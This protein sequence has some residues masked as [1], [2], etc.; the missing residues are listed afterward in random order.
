VEE[1][2]ISHSPQNCGTGPKA[3]RGTSA[4]C[5]QPLARVKDRQLGQ[6]V[7]LCCQSHDG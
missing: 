5:I 6:S 3:G 2:E 1:V 4:D 7:F